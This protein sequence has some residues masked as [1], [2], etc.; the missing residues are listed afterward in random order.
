MATEQKIRTLDNSF[1][2]ANEERKNK[3]IIKKSKKDS[4]NKI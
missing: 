1:Y 2:R 3:M 4:Q